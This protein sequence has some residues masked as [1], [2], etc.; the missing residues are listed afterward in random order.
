[1]IGAV[2]VLSGLRACVS[3]LLAERDRLPSP[4][5]M[6]ATRRSAA[7]DCGRSCNWTVGWGNWSEPGLL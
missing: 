1:M 2:V 4:S 5:R 6:D 7:A 3:E